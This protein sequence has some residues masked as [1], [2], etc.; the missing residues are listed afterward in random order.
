MKT[1]NA[2]TSMLILLLV[3]FARGPV[4][5][6]AENTALTDSEIQL[7]IGEK[8]RWPQVSP[9]P[10][11]EQVADEKDFP[12][13]DDRSSRVMKDIPPA[14]LDADGKPI[15]LPQIIVSEKAEV[16]NVLINYLN[17]Y[18]INAVVDP[19][20]NCRLNINLHKVRF[21]D[22]FRHIMQACKLGYRSESNILQIGTLEN[23]NKRKAQIELVTSGPHFLHYLTAAE[24]KAYILGES[25]SDNQDGNVDSVGQ[26]GWGGFSEKASSG[27]DTTDKGLLSASDN[28]YGEPAVIANETT[29]S[30]T[31]RDLPENVERIVRLIKELDQPAQQIRIQA[32]VIETSDSVARAIGVRWG[33]SLNVG[34]GTQIFSSSP[35][36]NSSDNSDESVYNRLVQSGIN[37]IQAKSG[38]FQS[39]SEDAIQAAA[40]AHV[41]P[42]QTGNLYGLGLGYQGGN[43]NIVAEMQALESSGKVKILSRPELVLRNNMAGSIATGKLL[44]VQFSTS[45]RVE[46]KEIQ[47]LLRL[48]VRPR[49]TSSGGVYLKVQ[50]RDDYVDHLNSVGA[51]PEIFKKEINTQLMVGNGK[52]VVLGGLRKNEQRNSDA[53]VPV[54]KDIPL[55]GQLFKYKNNNTD[56]DELVIVLRPTVVTQDDLQAS[57]MVVK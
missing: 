33:M 31:I 52:T 6:Q 29:N 45:D 34:G 12:G 10:W 24:A 57:S 43:G 13:I 20:I 44:N 32:W 39:G 5:A 15:V 50:V 49:I 7:C 54:L 51:I 42:T 3:L 27:T 36:L 17:D 38:T 48:T 46:V 47:A 4:L 19:D 23:I 41:S 40:E 2:L 21:W 35:N 1:G 9:T 37:A 14:F 30:I 22:A 8:D 25:F 53:G 55:L 16:R 11:L 28:V 26:Q 18:S 56:F